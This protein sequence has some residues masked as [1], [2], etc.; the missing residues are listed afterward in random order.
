[1]VRWP[2]GGGLPVIVP[3]LFLVSF[4][5]VIWL[6]DLN[7]RLCL[8]DSNDVKSLI[9]KNELQKLLTFDQVRRERREQIVIDPPWHVSCLLNKDY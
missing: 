3:L 5:V 1:M 4:S 2:R 7:Y 9:T 8:P 6:G